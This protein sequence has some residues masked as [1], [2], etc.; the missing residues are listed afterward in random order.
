MA[1]AVVG[2]LAPVC[3][4]D[5]NNPITLDTSE[6]LFAVLTA[7]NTC[8][9]NAGLNISDA[10]RLNIR[11]E[12]ERNLKSSEEAQATMT[13]MCDWYLAHRGKDPSHDLSQYVSL[14]LYL[15]G[16]PHFLPRVKED[17]MPPDA[18]SIA[19]FGAWCS[20]QISILECSRED[21]WGGR[22]RYIW[23]F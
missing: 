2:L 18:A 14:A 20:T 11:A 17:E 13:T 3:L 10:Q 19:A 8:G 5:A 1:V 4:A 15:Q 23:I 22:S 6:T 7:M 21:I 9:Y 12:V 16:P